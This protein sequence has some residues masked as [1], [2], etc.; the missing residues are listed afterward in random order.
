MRRPMMPRRPPVPRSV[1]KPT[2][3]RRR[4]RTRRCSARRSPCPRLRARATATCSSSRRP[5]RAATGPPPPSSSPPPARRSGCA[6]A[7]APPASRAR[8]SASFNSGRPWR[9][10]RQWSS[11]RT[12][13]WSASR[14]AC[15][16]SR[17]STCTAWSVCPSNRSS[18][19]PSQQSRS[20]S[21]GCTACLGR[22][23]CCRCNW[24]MPPI[25]TKLWPPIR[26]SSALGKTCGWTIGSLICAPPP[27]RESS[28]SSPPCASTFVNFSS[29]KASP[30]FTRQSSSARRPK[31]ELTS[32]KWS[33]LGEMHTWP[34]LRSSTSRWR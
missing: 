11:P 1:W 22:S 5:G 34:S 33:T 27:I 17:L 15:P 7:S 10:F 18:H 9:R 29:R 14:P 32:S 21:R 20:K 2:R 13:R 6:H 28:A 8:R 24:T 16:R 23:R 30:R 26:T 31:A 25:L 3:P 12:A 19:A 4:P